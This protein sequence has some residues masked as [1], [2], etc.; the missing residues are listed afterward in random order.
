M[1][2]SP[3]PDVRFWNVRLVSMVQIVSKRVR[4]R[5]TQFVESWMDLARALSLGSVGG[6]VV[7]VRIEMEISDA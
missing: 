5:M 6:S 4:V 2:F 1:S 3:V 7:T